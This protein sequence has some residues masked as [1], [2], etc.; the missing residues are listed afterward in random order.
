[1]RNYFQLHLGKLCHLI[2][3]G[4]LLCELHLLYLKVLDHSQTL[5][6]LFP[7]STLFQIHN[8]LAAQIFA[9]LHSSLILFFNN[10]LIYFHLIVINY[11]YDFLRFIHIF[12]RNFHLT[13]N[14]LDYIQYLINFS[15]KNTLLM[16]LLKLSNYL[17]K[18]I[19]LF[20]FF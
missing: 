17:L 6:F 11:F 3:F 13:I 9:H 14:N 18:L 7:L 1:M 5:H 2:S 19:L 4:C 10:T 16:N 12:I 15:F 8:I 20:F